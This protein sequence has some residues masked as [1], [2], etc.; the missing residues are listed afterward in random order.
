MKSNK[1]NLTVLF[2]LVAAFV[3]IVSC[4]HKTPVET[5]TLKNEVISSPSTFVLVKGTQI[6]K[7]ELHIC[8]KQKVNPNGKIDPV[9][10]KEVG[11]FETLKLWDE[12]TTWNSFYGTSP[13]YGDQ[14]ASFTPLD[15]GYVV[16]TSAG[17]TE[18]V[19]SWIDGGTN[20]G[21]FLKQIGECGGPSFRELYHS[22]EASSCNPFLRI[23]LSSTEYVDDIP[24]MDTEI[25][26]IYPT[27]SFGGLNE[28]GTGFGSCP[29]PEKQSLL[30]WDFD[31]EEEEDG[32]S[33][34][35]GY[36]KTH[37][38]HTISLLPLWLGTEGGD[39]S[40]EV[41][42]LNAW[43]IFDKEWGK[44]SNGILKLY[45]HL[46]A[47]KLNIANGTAGSVVSTAIS[48]AD[49]FIAAHPFTE[50]KDLSK[51]DQNMVLAWKDLLD[52]YNNG[53]IGPGHCD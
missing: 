41:T 24:D 52:A 27:A 19:Q 44:P 13:Q 28:L 36:W 49:E 11:V 25:L 6:V 1:T 9:N 43:E 3:L 8:V 14:V 35:P 10:G 45:I 15:W 37:E 17:L 26:E 32:C 48:E 50:W 21:I 22:S 34:T 5:P 40:I 2:L 38:E 7:A 53:D 31:L 12:T 51:A 47:A 46:L 29:G 23:Y 42:A 20:Y 16:V 30:I 33:L 4:E 18:L 39:H